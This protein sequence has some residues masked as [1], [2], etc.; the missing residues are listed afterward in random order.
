[1]LGRHLALVQLLAALARGAEAS[2][3]ARSA[4]T[5]QRFAMHRRDALATALVLPATFA[6]TRADAKAAPREIMTTVA[7]PYPDGK[8]IEINRRRFTGVGDPKWTYP[9]KDVSSI[10][11]DK[12][13]P[14]AW[15]YDAA[16]DFRRLD[17]EP[18]TK[19]YRP[20]QPKLLYH[21]DEGAVASLTHYY[22]KAI[23]P[24]SDILDICSSWVSHYPRNFPSTMASITGT[25]INE[26]ELAANDQFTAG[27][28]QA[29]LNANPVLPFPD[30]SFDVVT[31]VVSFDYLTKPREVM[32]E[33]VRVLRPGGKVILSQSNRCFYTKAVGVWTA[34]MSDSAHLRVLATYMHFADGLETP[35]ALDISAR[36]PGTN[37]PMYIVEATRT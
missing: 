31:C 34:D 21:I 18:D 23:K 5:M 24:K 13:F 1:M 27:Y 16:D 7:L 15:P 12:P 36:G 22:E 29:D 11:L 33:V 30:Q 14:E 26:I 20:Y 25:G 10:I 9:V 4:A 37:D 35:K 17:E 8:K 6:S 19:F 32:R 28:K 3:T 2:P